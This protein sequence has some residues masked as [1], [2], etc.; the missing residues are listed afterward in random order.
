MA[1][2]GRCARFFGNLFNAKSDKLRLDTIEGLLQWPVTNAL[3]F[4]STEN[5]GIALLRSIPDAKAVRPDERPVVFL[6]VRL[7][8]D[9][10]VLRE[11]RLVIK[12]VW[13]QRKLS[14]QWRDA[15]IKVLHN[16]KKDRIKFGN[17][18]GIILVAH[19]GKVLLKLVATRL[20]AYCEANE[21][22]PE[23]QCGFCL[24]RSTTDMMFTVRRL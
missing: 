6:K 1:F 8:H 7:N 22:L 3:R 5:K 11:F 20:S 14:Q 4:E 18:R 12:L 24:H 19:A 13:H 10:T 16:K 17:Y 2:P 9:P 15:L 23:E 21:L